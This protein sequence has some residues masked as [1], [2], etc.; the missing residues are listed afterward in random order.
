MARRT[1]TAIVDAAARLLAQ[2]GYRATTVEALAAEAD[3][4]IGTIYARFGGK[5]DVYLALAERE[6]GANEALLQEVRARG[7]SALEELV[8]LSDAYVRFHREHPLAF[9]VVALSDL[10]EAPAGRVA[11]VRARI[12][13]RLDAMLDL[14]AD[15]LRRAI[16]DGTVRRVPP[17][18]TARLLWAAT[19]GLLALHARG[20]I[21]QR[22]LRA[23][24]ELWRSV[25]LDGLR[26]GPEPQ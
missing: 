2:R 11:E 12:A 7:G 26:A 16:A 6:V 18:R 10:D 17:K 13:A 23:S 1:E 9:R 22:E 25:W 4:A 14:Y 15:A 8:A 5:Q 3:V 24:L 21:S 20:G 19:N